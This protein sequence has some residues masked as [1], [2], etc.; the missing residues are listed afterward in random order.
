MK[1]AGRKIYL[2]AFQ[3]GDA[4]ELAA[5]H[6][7]NRDYFSKFAASRED[8]YFTVMYQ[9]QLIQQ[10]IQDQFEDARYCFGVF[11]ANKNNLIGIVML[12]EIARGPLQSAYL[13]YCIDQQVSGNGY[14]S[15]AVNLLVQYGL[16][17]LHLHRIEANVMPDNGASIRVLEKNRF[18]KEGLCRKSIQINGVWEDHYLYARINEGET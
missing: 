16:N 1:L 10:F 4:S 13:G 2:R 17:Q 8:S 7:R 12:G 15:E 11:E 14:A 9:M 3:L 5:F 18:E 6:V